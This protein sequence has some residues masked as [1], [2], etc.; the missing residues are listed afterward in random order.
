MATKTQVVLV[1]DLTGES[2]DT[3]VNF[4]L[5]KTEYEIDLSHE[6]A[7]ALREALSRTSTLLEGFRATDAALPPPARRPTRAST[8]PLSAHGR[9]G[10]VSRSVPGDASRL[11]SSSSSAPLAT[12]P[13]NVRGVRI[14]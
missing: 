3:T 12:N 13:L 6:N 2:A 4:A 8:R 10:R 1:D 11:T 9:L 14:R 7:T 5:D